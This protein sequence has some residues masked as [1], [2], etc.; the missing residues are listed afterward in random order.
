MGLFYRREQPQA[1]VPYRVSIGQEDS[2]LIIGLGNPGKQ[3]SGTRH[4]VGF[5]C[6]DA[7]AAAENGSWTEKKQLKSLICQL[8][9]GQ[10]RLLLIK[11]QTF[12]NNS[13]EAARAVQD[14]FKIDNAR[15]VVVHDELDITFGQIRSRMGGS[16]AGNNGVKSLI[17]HIGEDFGR[18]RVGVA[19]EFAGQTDSADFV[20]QAFSKAEQGSLEAL[21]TEVSSILNEF[22]FG[23]KLPSDT[24][25]FVL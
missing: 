14:Y 13:G 19:N 4:N 7:F 9:L 10:T 3:Y 1:E 11:P 18:I 5:L 8:T 25:S 6:V 21:T 17:Q 2:K 15:T 20:L 24:R 12:M 22:V 23:G 16:A